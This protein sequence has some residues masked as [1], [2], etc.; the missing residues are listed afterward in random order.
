MSC[1]RDHR[2]LP[3]LYNQPAPTTRTTILLLTAYATAGK[4]GEAVT[5]S[6]SAERRPARK[7]PTQEQIA[8]HYTRAGNTG[9][10][11]YIPPQQEA[12]RHRVGHYAG[13]HPE[14]TPY[15]TGEM[16]QG[17]DIADE[18]AL[19]DDDAYYQTRLPTSS[20]RYHQIPA[21][22]PTKGRVNVV[23]HYHEQ[24]LRAHRTAYQQLPPSRPRYRE[25]L[26]D[27]QPARRRMHPLVWIGSFGMFLVL[28]WIGLNMV[29]SWWQGVQDTWTYGQLRHFTVDAVVGHS[30]STTSP[31][32]FTAENNR[33]NIY[34]IE[35]PGGDT[36][37]AHIYQITVIPENS[38]NP[39][40]KL[41]FQDLNRD[42]K[43]NMLVEI[44]EPG[45]Y[46]TIMLF[47]NGTQFVAKG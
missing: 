32:H 30:D 28:G 38:G 44:G 15:L 25:E 27:I 39:P 7:I 3:G 13:F 36:A 6:Y 22:L 19:E 9:N 42:G 46:I 34:V 45:S 24:P 20:R 11:Q 47:N 37:K 29:S 17:V 12:S 16:Q 14:D 23:E 31:S 41:A 35:L 4:P 1:V 10:Q 33:G 21:V 2:L 18:Y 26:T 40:V 8:H 5:S 43:L